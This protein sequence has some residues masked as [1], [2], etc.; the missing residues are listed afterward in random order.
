MA[1][2]NKKY[3]KQLKTCATQL[4]KASKHMYRHQLEPTKEDAEYFLQEIE[5]LGGV[6]EAIKVDLNKEI[7][8][9]TTKK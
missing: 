1:T 2:T 8:L 6:I 7:K 4:I 5:L 3:D 9:L